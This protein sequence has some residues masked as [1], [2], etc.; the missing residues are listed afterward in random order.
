MWMASPGTCSLGVPMSPGLHNGHVRVPVAQGLI[1]TER[2][3][4]QRSHPHTF[5]VLAQYSECSNGD[6]L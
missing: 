3:R 2:K 4:S 6:Y 5:C 1:S